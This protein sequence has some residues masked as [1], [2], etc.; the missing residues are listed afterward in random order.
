MKISESYRLGLFF[1]GRGIGAIIPLGERKKLKIRLA[2]IHY[3]G[4]EKLD[5]NS[6]QVRAYLNDIMAARKGN[7]EAANRLQ[8]LAKASATFCIYNREEQERL[9]EN[10]LSFWASKSRGA[11]NRLEPEEPDPYRTAYYRD[12]G[13]IVHSVAFRNLAGKT[14]VFAFP[15]SPSIHTRAFHSIKVAQLAESIGQALGLNTTLIWAIGLGHDLGHSPFGHPGEKVLDDISHRVLDNVSEKELL[16][17]KKDHNSYPKFQHHFR[18]NI[19]SFRIASELEK[20][21]PNRSGLNLTLEV[22]DGILHHWGEGNEYVLAPRFSPIYEK[23]LKERTRYREITLTK[24]EIT[25]LLNPQED[26]A[27]PL[28]YEGCVVRLADRIAYLPVDLE[29][30]LTHGFIREEALLEEERKK[31]KEIRSILG[32]TPREMFNTLVTNTIET[33]RKI[34]KI[35]M[36]DTIG[37][38]M[39]LLQEFNYKNIYLH[40]DKLAFEEKIPFIFETLFKYYTEVMGMPPREAIDQIASLTDRQVLS[41]FQRVTIPQSLV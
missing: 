19:Q 40:S 2:D 1:R 13:R 20:Y 28:T 18:H 5:I 17:H 35:A 23:F 36:S 15:K 39:N 10:T 3:F 38:A 8:L 26:R 24:E 41:E 12:L 32:K 22:L 31:L 11:G 16:E 4:Q 7:R 21:L 30:A 25:S 37:R 34:G 6:A 33:S 29:D 9:E 14:Q 27:F